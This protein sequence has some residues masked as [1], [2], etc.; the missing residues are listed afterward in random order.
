[1]DSASRFAT[2]LVAGLLHLTAAWAAPGDL[3]PTFGSG[4]IAIA[5][6]AA[7]NAAG[8]ALQGDGRIVA[9]G[10]AY[11]ARFD[12]QG[13]LDPTFGVNGVVA[14][15]AGGSAFNVAVM[16]DGR[17]VTLGS[18]ALGRYL[19]SGAPDILFGAAGATSTGSTAETTPNALA[20][21]PDGRALVTV[22]TNAF[23]FKR[24]NLDGSLDTTFGSAGT[25]LEPLGIPGAVASTP[26]GGAIMVGSYFNNFSRELR[27]ARYTANGALESTTAASPPTLAK[28]TVIQGSTPNAIVV[29]RDGRIVV[30]GWDSHNYYDFKVAVWRFLADGSPDPTFGLG[31]KV[32]TPLNA[33]SGARAIAVQPDGRILA[34][35][36]TNEATST[37]PPATGIARMALLRYLPNGSLDPTFGNGG[38]VTVPFATPTS[39]LSLGA[40]A[41]QPDGKLLAAVSGTPQLG[42]AR[43]LLAP[44]IAYAQPDA[45]SDGDGIPNGMEFAA[46]GDPLVKDNDVFGDTRLFAMQQYRD[47]LRREGDAGGVGYWAAQIDSHALMRSQVIESFVASPEF[48]G[49]IAPVVRLYF[50]YFLRI[51]DYGGIDYWTSSFRGGNSLAA[52]S[53][54]FALSAEFAGMYGALDNAAFVERVYQNV[55]GRPADPAGRAHWNAQLDSGA[56]SRG[57]MMIGFSESPEYS[58]LTANEVFV[59]MAYV[60]MMRRAPDPGGFSFW[61]NYM[62]AGNSARALIDGFIPSAEYRARFLP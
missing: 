25:V 16:P 31:G 13:A 55:L 24:F 56:I 61:V 5:P 40:L 7:A 15:A 39:L 59:T 3:D 42:I 35:G 54:T 17:I 9:V 49:A 45:D 29:Q 23:T 37:I 44:D 27:L 26:Q 20:L 28:L 10:G 33:S 11:I 22:Y 12:A 14:P 62:D 57:Q 8:V 48:Q 46:G 52:I 53:E 6:P 41:L 51:P 34:A 2:G 38:L 1:M 50:A 47:F 4:G 21:Q 43:F 36:W 30:G 58:S 19:G 32:T 18:N 60:G